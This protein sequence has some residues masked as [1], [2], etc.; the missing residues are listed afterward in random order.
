MPGIQHNRTQVGLRCR[1]TQMNYFCAVEL[2]GRS[3]A[4][5]RTETIWIS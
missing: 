1:R 4:F 2:A 3:S 5:D